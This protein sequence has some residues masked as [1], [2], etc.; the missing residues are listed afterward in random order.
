[1]V[2]IFHF[3]I[4]CVNGESQVDIKVPQVMCCMF[5]YSK[6]ISHT[7]FEPTKNVK[8]RLYFIFQK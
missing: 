7:I 4:F 1:M 2:K 6:L 3:S 5:Y 8:E